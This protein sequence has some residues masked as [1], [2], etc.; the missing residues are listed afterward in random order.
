[1]T[2]HCTHKCSPCI[3]LTWAIFNFQIT[4]G[5]HFFLPLQGIF[6]HSCLPHPCSPSLT[7]ISLGAKLPP[8]EK[9]WRPSA[10]CSFASCCLEYFWSHLCLLTPLLSETIL[11]IISSDTSAPWPNKQTTNTDGGWGW[12]TPLCSL[13]LCAS[14]SY[15]LD[16]TA[17]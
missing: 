9:R 17:L 5:S 13:L 15:S 14:F 3:E 10:C 6:K 8:A 12:N 2:W 7:N 16:A 4:T 11:Y 1:M